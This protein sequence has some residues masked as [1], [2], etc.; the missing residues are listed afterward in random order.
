MNARKNKKRKKG[1]LSRDEIKILYRRWK[2]DP[3]AFAEDVFGLRLWS[4]QKRF[5]RA[6]AKHRKV[7]CRSGHKIG[8]TLSFAILAWW[9]VTVHYTA[10]V[11]VIAPR[12]TQ[13]QEGL[14]K[15][16][17][18]LYGKALERGLIK[19]DC[20]AIPLQA[21]SGVS[22]DS[23]LFSI[24][25]IA[26][27]GVKANPQK[28]AGFS[29]ENL[30]YLI[31]EASAVDIE[32]VW[33][34]CRTAPSGRFYAI[35]NPTE[36]SPLNEFYKACQPGS[37]WEHLHIPSTEAAAENVQLSDGSYLYPG[38]A[39]NEWVDENKGD[40]EKSFFWQVRI[41]GNFPETSDKTFISRQV[42]LDAMARWTPDE[43]SYGALSFGVDLAWSPDG[44]E[45][46]FTACRGGIW[47]SEPIA[48]RAEA[49][50]TVAKLVTVVQ[51]MRRKLPNGYMEPVLI[52]V[53]ATN[54]TTTYH[55]IKEAY[56]QDPLVTVQAVDSSGKTKRHHIA[57]GLKCGLVR[58]ALYVG[59]AEFLAN[60]AI[61]NDPKLELDLITPRWDHN[62]HGD[63]K[64]ESKK[65]IRARTGK[66]PDR[67]D[68]LALA[69]YPKNIQYSIGGLATS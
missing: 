62:A 47:A 64:I 45:S 17:S 13:L 6:C 38:L 25:G 20:R 69:V 12:S 61:P 30:A 40:G 52:N 1:S 29:G 65:E 60:G 32:K 41:M 31:D 46:V 18:T 35:S 24:R 15:E 57:T 43:P 54:Q 2:N 49:P 27:D 5:L 59:V 42:V 33:E 7:A 19:L 9:L 50:K 4:G 16:L 63:L 34:V 53:D 67:G 55:Y 14:W 22:W 39:T 66:S 11:Y 56:N 68:S 3:V 8:K 51:S 26:A 10:R 37:G 48:F 36:N 21:S 23:G 44:D 28:M 58:D